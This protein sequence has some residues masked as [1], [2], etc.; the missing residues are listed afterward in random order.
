MLK[1]IAK[2][3]FCKFE[4]LLQAIDAGIRVGFAYTT[5]GVVSSP[6]EG[7]TGLKLNKT[8]EGKDYFVAY[9][10]GPIRS[11]GDYGGLCCFDDY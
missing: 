3:R 10:S 6:L 7:F 8:R 4:S 1:E 9:F 5:I 2:E 11:A